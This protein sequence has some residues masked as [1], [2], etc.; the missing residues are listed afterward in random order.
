MAACF[1]GGFREPGQPLL[2]ILDGA[3]EDSSSPARAAH[4]DGE[5]TV[6]REAEDVAEA[7]RRLGSRIRLGDP[8]RALIF[9]FFLI[10]TT[11]SPDLV[12]SSPRRMPE[13]YV[14]RSA[15]KKRVGLVITEDERFSR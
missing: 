1:Q 3:G 12:K 2:E 5:E 10:Y 8:A 4:T 7:R 15:S 14:E 9:L 6:H 13:R 11:T